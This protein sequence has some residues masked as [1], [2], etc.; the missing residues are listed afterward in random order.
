MPVLFSKLNR[1]ATLHKIGQQAVWLGHE[2]TELALFG[3]GPT[4][5]NRHAVRLCMFVTFVSHGTPNQQNEPKGK[6]KKK[7]EG[8]KG[9]ERREEGKGLGYILLLLH[10]LYGEK[11]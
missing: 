3:H 10:A 4:L 1:V 5:Q 11:R 9:E 7:K 8:C 6:G 2:V